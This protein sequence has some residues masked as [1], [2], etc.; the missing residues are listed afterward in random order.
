MADLKVFKD[1]SLESGIR[2]DVD[3]IL[4]ELN[5][6]IQQFNALPLNNI[7]TLND[8][9]LLVED[10][11]ALQELKIGE[12]TVIGGVTI[13]PA[14][15]LKILN[16]DTTEIEKNRRKFVGGGMYNGKH[17]LLIEVCDVSNNVLVVNNTKLENYIEAQVYII[18][19]TTAQKA[20]YNDWVALVDKLEAFTTKYK[21]PANEFLRRQI[22]DYFS[23]QGNS[24]AGFDVNLNKFKQILRTL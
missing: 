7:I 12:P 18:L 11:Q 15:V 2:F 22:F 17:N 19:S 5:E 10:F 4:P 20:L 16:F 8:V 3:N 24:Q 6:L 21:L 14:Q 9:R 13:T 23:L 1:T